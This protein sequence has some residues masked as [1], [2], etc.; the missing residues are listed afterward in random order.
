MRLDKVRE[1]EVAKR[2]GNT[3]RT[4][5]QL[6]WFAIT[7]IMAYFIVEWLLAERYISFSRLYGGGIPRVIPEWLLQGGLM[8]IV[9]IVIQFFFLMGYLI[10]S[11]LGRKRSGRPT[12]RSWNPDPND[13]NRPH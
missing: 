1:Q 8:L 5:L 11:P 6:I 4:I 3:G 2:Q 9:V 10:A 13:D 12:L 7:F